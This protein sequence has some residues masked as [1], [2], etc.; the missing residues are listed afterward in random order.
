M[1][2]EKAIEKLENYLSTLIQKNSHR[3]EWH[4]YIDIE[5]TGYSIDHLKLQ[6]IIIEMTNEKCTGNKDNHRKYKINIRYQIG[7]SE[8]DYCHCRLENTLKEVAKFILDFGDMYKIC[9]D[10]GILITKDK[11]CVDCEFFRILNEYRGITNNVCSICHETVLRTMLPCGHYFHYVCILQLEKKNI[12][13]PNCRFP[14]PKHVCD[15]LF[16]DE[17][18]EQT[19]DEY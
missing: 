4:H 8:K 17:D 10:C 2:K 3:E 12:K 5:N 14:I 11:S 1:D 16:R 9:M 15:S 13:C 7:N 18:E 6:D 19:D